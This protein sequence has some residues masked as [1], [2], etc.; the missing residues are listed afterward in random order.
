MHLIAKS[1]IKQI[2]PK[3]AIFQ[4]QRGLRNFDTINARKI[5]R[6]SSNTPALLTVDELEKLCKQY[7]PPPE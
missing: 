4:L 6:R 3:S 5:F 2:V 7:P 1:A